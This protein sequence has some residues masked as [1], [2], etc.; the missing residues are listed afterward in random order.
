MPSDADRDHARRV[1]CGWASRSCT[2][3]WGSTYLGDRGRRRD[4]PAVPD[5]RGAVR[6]AGSLL[7]GWISSAARDSI[8]R[9]T[10]REVR[11]AS[12]VGALLLGGGMGFVAWGEQTIPSGWPPFSSR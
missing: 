1:G 7:L 3:V 10:R 5:G 6:L 11:D 2:L 9:P 4:H 8:V 12:I